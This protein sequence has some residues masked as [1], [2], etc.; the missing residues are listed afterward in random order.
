MIKDFS[1]YILYFSQKK[2]PNQILSDKVIIEYSKNYKELPQVYK[3]VEKEYSQI[4]NPANLDS[5]VIAMIYCDMAFLSDEFICY[6][7]P[8]LIPKAIERD[9][10]VLLQHLKKIKLDNLSK[11]DSYIIQKLITTM[12]VRSVN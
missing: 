9:D 7:L 1:E 12:E 10:L 8:V 2:K 6:C 3:D 4:N 11:D 5:D